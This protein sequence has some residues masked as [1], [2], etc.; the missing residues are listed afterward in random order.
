[1]AVYRT[2]SR[3]SSIYSKSVKFHVYFISFILM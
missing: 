3:S 2:Y 1:M